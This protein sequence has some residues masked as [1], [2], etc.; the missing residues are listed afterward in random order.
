MN[1]SLKMKLAAFGAVAI[2]MASFGIA[3]ADTTT[4]TNTG[5]GS[6]NVVSTTNTVTHV[7]TNV[8][9]TTVTNA[10]TQ[11]GTTGNA[12]TNNNTGAGGAVTGNVT[13][14]NSFGTSIAINNTGHVVPNGP[15]PSN[16]AGGGSGSA[17]EK[18]TESVATLPKTGGDGIDTRLFNAL[19]NAPKG[20]FAPLPKTGANWSWAL[21][22]LA[23][24]LAVGSAM[25]YDKYK[26]A[27][28]LGSEV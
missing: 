19:N 4:I 24:A 22:A 14:S 28:M 13:N 15:T 25:T 6:S 7:V 1:T 16:I 26:K 17:T 5:P 10:N 18:T 2:S 23:A 8:N 21:T 27:K 12:N 3:H 9:T 11:T 20:I